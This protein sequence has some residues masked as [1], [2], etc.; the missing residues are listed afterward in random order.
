[1]LIF[2]VHLTLDFK[3]VD[4]VIAVFYV[5]HRKFC[6]R[7]YFASSK[8]SLPFYFGDTQLHAF[9]HLFAKRFQFFIT[10]LHEHVLIFRNV[11]LNLKA[12]EF[13]LRFS[14]ISPKISKKIRRSYRE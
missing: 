10:S 4:L 12:L 3:L 8:D 5:E 13:A 2:L 6:L 1:M 11:S 14:R 9:H 7:E